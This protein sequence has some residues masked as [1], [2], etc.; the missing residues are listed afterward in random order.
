MPQIPLF[1]SSAK[2]GGSSDGLFDVSFSPPLTLPEDAKNCTIEIQQAEVPFTTSNVTASNN[3]LV[4]ALPNHERT[5]SVVQPGAATAIQKFNVSIPVAL[6]DLAALEMA[7]NRAVNDLVVSDTQIGGPLYKVPVTTHT[8]VARDGT[9]AVNVPA[10]VDANWLMFVPDYANNLLN[11]RLNYPGSA[12]YF[13][14]TLST[15]ARSCGDAP[16]WRVRP[17]RRAVGRNSRSQATPH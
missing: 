14:D 3:T 2:A 11:I 15:L 7:I 9:S 16:P 1:V 4:I 12:I 6:Y 10:P 8:T 5:T 13:S 17:G